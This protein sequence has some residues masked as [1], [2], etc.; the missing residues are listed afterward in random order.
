[1]VIDFNRKG[2]RMMQGTETNRD[3]E[4]QQLAYRLWQESGCPDG[5]AVEHWLKAELIWLEGHRPQSESKHSKTL[6]G[7]KNRQTQTTQREL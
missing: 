4:I 2:E 7:R 5:Y 6:K 1:M 3:E